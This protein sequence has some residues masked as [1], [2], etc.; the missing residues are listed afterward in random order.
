ML[1]VGVVTPRNQ[2]VTHRRPD[3][4]L[5]VLFVSGSWGPSNHDMDGRAIGRAYQPK[6]QCR[7]S[8]EAMRILVFDI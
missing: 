2:A 1:D 8:R 4:G 5:G 6:V 7:G 3:S